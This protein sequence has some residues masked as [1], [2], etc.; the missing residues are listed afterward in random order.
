IVMNSAAGAGSRTPE[1]LPAP[2]KIERVAF[3]VPGTDI[4]AQTWYALYG[5]LSEDV[6][7]LI[8][9]HGGPGMAH[10]Y[11]LPCAHLASAPFSR[12]VILYDQIGCG[13]STHLREKKGDTDFW[14]SDLFIAELENL[15]SYLG[16][17]KFD[18]FGQSWGGMLGALYATKRPA[19]LYRLIVAN[20]P[21]SLNTWVEV[22][23]NLR[24]ELPKDIQ[25]T[26][27][28]CEEQ[29]TTDTEEY[30]TAMMSFYERHVCRV[31]PFPDELVQTLD[32]VKDDDTVYMTMNGPSEFN[33]IGSL[34][35]WDI[36]SELH[37]INVPT[38]L[39]NGNYDEAQDITMEPYFRE[40]PGKV[41][42]VRFPES[43]H[44]PHLEETDAFVEAVGN[45]LTS[46]S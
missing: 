13:N 14:T 4:E 28:R 1:T 35:G 21:A 27:T 32:Q 34:K 31:V 10:N 23:D 11:I 7:P 25:E 2:S 22:A 38:L 5:K 37:K 17:K 16:I 41:K 3:K 43:S 40:I 42:W 39:I 46:E 20:S 29:G 6:T 44:C 26:L 24:K 18:L 45:F 12:P 15:L 36:T 33:V 30:E 8:C 9:L 19:G